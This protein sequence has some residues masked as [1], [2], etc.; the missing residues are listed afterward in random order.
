MTRFALSPQLSYR[1]LADQVIVVDHR[2]AELLRLNRAAG[3]VLDG[4]DRGQRDW[5]DDDL[6]FIAALRERGWIVTD[7]EHS[8]DA[9]AAENLPEAVA[10][11]GS[12]ERRALID[13]LNDLAAE[14]LVPLHAQLELTYRCPLACSH[15]YLHSERQS[16]MAE[17]STEEVTGLLD[18]LAQLGTLFLL[19]TGGEIFARDDLE[20]I[21]RHARERRFAVTLLTSGFDLDRELM[22]RLAWQ[23]LDCV[24]VSLHGAD[25]A[26][27]ETMTGVP[28]SFAAALF[29]LRFFRDLGVRTQAAITVTRNNLDSLE[30]M[31]ELCA[32]ER[33]APN[34]SHYVEPRRDGSREPQSLLVDEAGLHRIEQ[35]LPSAGAARL[36]GREASDRPCG[37]GASTVAVD[38]QGTVYP[39]HTLRIPVGSLRN[40]S[41]RDIWAQSKKLQEIRGIK[42]EDLD[43]CL[44]CEHRSHCN[45]CAGFAV[46]EGLPITGHSPF[47]C[48]LSRV[49]G[50]EK[51]RRSESS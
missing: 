10:P 16:A 37:A 44:S 34:L 11:G 21:V 7:D 31:L 29:T 9:A 4:L 30:A 22:T 42:T 14:S 20:P 5:S 43:E 33:I 32:R 17:L 12:S 47:D 27:H 28:G 8:S 49:I 48:L 3:D 36:A 15:C 1:H 18:E 6:E 51:E 25:A 35:L 45:R 26:T 39:C 13:R 38:P 40:E 50:S 46:A 2:R 41:L 24:Q 23:G 19:L